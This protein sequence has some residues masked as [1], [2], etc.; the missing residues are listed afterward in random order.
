MIGH[1]LG[2]CR[3]QRVVILPSISAVYLHGTP[4]GI[5]T[6]DV[7]CCGGPA[8]QWIRNACGRVVGDVD[9]ARV[10]LSTVTRI[11]P[12]HLERHLASEL[13]RKAD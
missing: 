10:Q 8:D 4:A 11:D 7:V 5:R 9:V 6:I 1:A 2:K 13:P 12:V 3:L